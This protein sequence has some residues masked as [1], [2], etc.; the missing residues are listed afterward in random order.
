MCCNGN[1][2][3]QICCLGWARTEVWEFDC[4]KT[5]GLGLVLPTLPDYRQAVASQWDSARSTQGQ[6]DT[7]RLSGRDTI[8]TKLS[9]ARLTWKPPS[10]SPA[11]RDFFLAGPPCKLSQSVRPVNLLPDLLCLLREW[12]TLAGH[13]S[14]GAWDPRQDWGYILVIERLLTGYIT[15]TS[16]SGLL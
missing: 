12:R 6:H 9:P 14:L 15:F 8:E 5:V 10:P 4:S 11:S 2:F 7:L 16:G 1:I 3:N 13:W